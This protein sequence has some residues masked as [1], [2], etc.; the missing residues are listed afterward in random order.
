MRSQALYVCAEPPMNRPTPKQALVPYQAPAAGAWAG[1]SLPLQLCLLCGCGG[2]PKV[3][4]DSCCASCG[5]PLAAPP[6]QH[7]LAQGMQGRRGAP[8]RG[9]DH[10]AMMHVGWPSSPMPV[11][12]RDLS[13]TGLSL[14]AERVIDI[15]DMIRVTDSGVDALAQVVEC[16]HQGRLHT[17]H[18]RLLRVRFLQTSGMFVSTKA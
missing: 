18:A 6:T 5:S 16:R 14:L 7:D 9:R 4:P 15:D 8:R 1:D 3:L 13:M 17:V 2:P 10:L 11:R 12:W